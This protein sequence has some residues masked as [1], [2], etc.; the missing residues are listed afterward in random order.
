MWNKAKLKFQQFLRTRYGWD[1]LNTALYIVGFAAL[2]LCYFLKRRVL[3]NFSYIVILIALFRAYS[4]NYGKRRKENGRFRDLIAP[5][6]TVWVRF[7]N[8]KYYRYVHCPSCNKLAKVPKGKGKVSI[9]CPYCHFV[10]ERR[11]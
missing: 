8:R 11:V 3:F 4:A 7:K 10:Y 1:E 5:F 6:R 2:I 9:R